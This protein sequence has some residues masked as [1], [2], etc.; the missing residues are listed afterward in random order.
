MAFSAFR[1]EGREAEAIVL[2]VTH[3]AS[4]PRVS[5]YAGIALE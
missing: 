5:L 1:P 2:S 4:T 3:A